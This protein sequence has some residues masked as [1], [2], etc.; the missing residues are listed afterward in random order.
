MSTPP[1]LAPP[2]ATRVGPLRTPRGAFAS[3]V[4]EPPDSGAR[5]TAVL[6]PGFTGSKEDFIAILAPLSAQGWRVVTYDQ[7]GQYETPGT[8]AGSYSFEALAD[9]L[10]A[11]AASVSEDP[12]HV[13]GHS[14]GGL[15][16]RQA[17]LARPEAVR[18][19]TLM[20]SG[21]KGVDGPTAEI[22]QVFAAALESMPI[23]DVWEAKVAYDAAQGL[24]LPADASLAAFLRARFVGNDPLGLAAFARLLINAPDRTAELGLTGCPVLVLYGE[25]DDAW[26]PAIQSDMAQRLGAR[27]Q[28]IPGA[29][30]SPA[31]EAPE[32][33]AE[34]LGEFWADPAPGA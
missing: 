30:H 3:W 20:D 4:I 33:T 21:P 18:S 28:V 26:S 15:V 7:R 1:F 32:R 2:P 17:V 23:Q 25:N 12:V 5:G 11:V 9:D 16:A 8:H 13:L 10:L 14:F 24:H 6:V 29:G 19:L 34:V 27:R 22:A 31:A